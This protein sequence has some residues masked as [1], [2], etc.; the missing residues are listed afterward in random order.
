MGVCL[1]PD[2]RVADTEDIY[3]CPQRSECLFFFWLLTV[4]L[5]GCLEE[6]EKEQ[7]VCQQENLYRGHKI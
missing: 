5:H 1:C 6:S 3:V 7:K 2:T 4:F